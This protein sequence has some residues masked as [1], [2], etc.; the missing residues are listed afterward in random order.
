[1]N[2][3]VGNMTMTALLGLALITA[4]AC[5]RT[6]KYTATGA[7]LGAASGAVVAGAT[8]GSVAGGALIGGAVGAGTGYVLS[9]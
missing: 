5:T 1:M 7:G 3:S 6:Q 9:K 8:G 2:R 4:G